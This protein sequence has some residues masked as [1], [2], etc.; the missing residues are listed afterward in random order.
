MKL[1]LLGASVMAVAIQVVPAQTDS[2]SYQLTLSGSLEVN[3]SYVLRYKGLENV[4]SLDL[5]GTSVRYVGIWM[6]RL[7]NVKVLNLSSIDLVDVSALT[8]KV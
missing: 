6:H 5:S 4:E 3:D 1:L 8:E 7:V 2:Q